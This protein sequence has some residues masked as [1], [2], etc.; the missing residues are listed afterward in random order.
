MRAVTAG[1][2]D[3][4]LLARWGR[5]VHRHRIRVLLIP[6]VVLAAAGVLLARG[7]SLS[8]DLQ[9]SGQT[10]QGEDLIHDQLPQYGRSSFQ[11]VFQSTSTT[12]ADPAFRTAVLDAL[13]PLRGDDRVARVVS[14]FDQRGDAANVSSADVGIAKDS[15]AAL[16]TVYLV[17]E[18]K[19]A[20]S[21]YGEIRDRIRSDTLQ[22][23]ATGGLAINKDLG[24]RLDKDLVKAEGI[25]FP[26]SLILLLIVFGTAIAAL[27]P[28][29]I[30][31]LAVMCAVGGILAVSAVMDV[32]D[33]APSMASLLGLG[34]AIDYSLFVVSRF[35]EELAGGAD[36][37]DALAA[38]VATAGRTVLFSGLS[39]AA[40]LAGLFFF[41][42]TFLPSLGVAAMLV[43][44][45]SLLFALTL[46]PSLLAMLGPSVNRFRVRPL[47]TDRDHGFW[48][49]ISYGVMKHP[50][51]VVPA[52]A[53]LVV[54]VI[55]FFHVRLETS[56]LNVLPRDTEARQ[57]QQVL[58]DKFANHDRARLTVIGRVPDSDP[59]A[60]RN[61]GAIYDLSR[62]LARQPGV[63]R[64]ESIVDAVPGA[65][66]SDY[67]RLYADRNAISDRLRPAVADTVGR[68]FVLLDV[69]ATAPPASGAARDLVGAL[70]NVSLDGGQ[71]LVIG[72]DAV[73]RD[74]LEIIRSA[75]PW[76]V[77]F[78]ILA[79]YVILLFS[80]R[81]VLLPAKAVLMTLLSITASFGA[82][83]WVFQDG[84]LASVLNF[85]ATDIDP[86]I[87]V[88][89][90]CL[91]FGLSMDYEVLLL[92]RIQE[93]Y[94]V[95]RDN[96]DAVAVGLQRS[97]RLITTAALIM[98]VVFGS[99]AVGDVVLIKALGVGLALAVAVDATIVR[100]V[101]VPAL[102]RLFGSANWWAPGRLRHPALANSSSPGPRA[103]NKTPDRAAT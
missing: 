4:S 45:L 80:M 32:S 86:V 8:L 97:G 19:K 41:R 78:V 28:I 6:L 37:E 60:E 64:V 70:R 56:E 96:R 29:G 85:T 24:A 22:V 92:N 89:L 54:A 74:L 14:P 69:V 49:A 52:M 48:R 55:P 15:S 44:L 25:S 77:G 87:P 23:S 98:V 58:A 99:F 73:S 31:G 76:A 18:F 2:S 7:G 95:S 101:A 82:L 27:L 93:A 42:G 90:F 57:A 67:Q 30:G 26:L 12:A 16:A 88:L 34:L 20:T 36:R 59:L 84:H 5:Y 103:V 11:V 9:V 102:M 46:L 21:Y 72:P 40:G 61:L 1:P 53:V 63:E 50:W 3:Q 62:T 38:T 94:L 10:R 79:V 35:R 66:K 83:V 13:A 75:T 17:D 100:C 33:F 68:D 39:V 51:L 91:V 47:R 71:V 43:V 65:S 81:S